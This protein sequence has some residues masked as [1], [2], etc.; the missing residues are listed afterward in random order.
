MILTG[1]LTQESM[2]ALT[3]LIAAAPAAVASIRDNKVTL[4]S[5]HLNTGQWYGLD[6]GPML[7]IGSGVRLGHYQE[8]LGCGRNLRAGLLIRVRATN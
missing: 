7:L 8:G 6:R 2:A 5:G 1:T 4:A 3:P